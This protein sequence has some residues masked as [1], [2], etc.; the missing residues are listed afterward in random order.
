MPLSSPDAT[1]ERQAPKYTPAEIRG[2]VSYVVAL[3]GNASPPI[4]KLDPAGASVAK[5]ATQFQLNCAACHDSTGVGGALF[6]RA[7]PPVFP[8]TPTQAA[9]A[10]RIGPGQMP[11][12]GRAALDHE[13]LNDTVAYV[14][15]LAHPRD[16]GGYALWHLGPL[17]EGAAIMVLGLGTLLLAT[18][19]IGTRT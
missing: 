3:T 4:P 13:Q 10:I 16:R 6:Q 11:V 5:G 12:F 17:A 15:Y 14:K 9:E 2:L 1:P 18:R 7:A 19:W 8:A